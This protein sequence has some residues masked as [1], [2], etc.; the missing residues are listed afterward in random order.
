MVSNRRR[1]LR[2][3]IYSDNYLFLNGLSENEYNTIALYLF[4]LT[5]NISNE[6]GEDNGSYSILK[7]LSCYANKKER[8]ESLLQEF[9]DDAISNN[10]L[11]INTS[12]NI[13]QDNSLSL[14][15]EKSIPYDNYTKALQSESSGTYAKLIYLIFFCDE[16]DQPSHID[17]SLSENM[18]ELLRDTS[19]VD[20]LKSELELSDNEALILQI[21]YRFTIYSKIFDDFR[22]YH[23]ET[24]KAFSLV[25]ELPKY[26]IEHMLLK[27]QKLRE[28]DF[29]CSNGLLSDD[30]EE[31]IKNQNLDL[32]FSTFIKEFDLPKT[33]DLNSFNVNKEETELLQEMLAGNEPISILLYGKPGSGK[34][35]YAKSIAKESGKKVIIFKN[36]N[37]NSRLY[38]KINLLLSL[39]RPNTILIIDEADTILFTNSKTT[40]GYRGSSNYKGIV[41][42]I[43]ENSKNQVIWI[44]NYP[45]MMDESTRRRFTLSC[46]FE[47]M[48][49]EVL[50]NI[51]KTKLEQT[52]IPVG[53]QEKILS[54]LNTYRVTGSSVD[55]IIKAINTIHTN[56]EETL[57]NKINIILKENARLLNGSSSKRKDVSP[58]YDAS[59]LNTSI[60]SEKIVR[61]VNNAVRFAEKN[62]NTFDIK[63]GI[64]MLFYGLSG[65]GKTEFARYIS[66]NLG[67]EILIKRA[68]DILNKYVGG[69]EEKIADA[70]SEATANDQILLFDEADTFFTDR[71]MAEHSWERTKVN[72]FLMQMEDFQGILI[73]TTNLKNIMDSAMQRRFHI[74]V[75]FKASTREGIAKLLSG[76]F[77]SFSF[78]DEHISRLE[79]YQS[80]TP[81]DVSRLAET[82][83]FMDEE[84]ICSDF[85]VEEL[86]KIEEEKNETHRRVGFM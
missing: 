15:N 10:R 11:S 47:A 31:C 83:R 24:E 60:S 52:K 25:S 77:S 26:E 65:T 51:T 57:L 16:S 63:K 56:D 66:Q 13:E 35:E 6:F 76:Y 68:S 8:F 9:V 40:I 36:E 85:I 49:A 75:E 79:R 61:M 71:N 86:C 43:L 4:Q 72:E 73:C 69:T 44:V 37:E 50:K 58:S 55:N 30:V 3:Y 39:N 84:E 45:D 82:I 74:S 20:F 64:R 59:V 2:S 7:E 78:T 5:K 22:A 29:I 33:Y 62:Q 28:Y 17:F 67:K 1:G 80:V 14:D 27:N 38:G 21:S 32:Y 34:T 70:F 23:D 81:G 12:E 41:N 46:R 19:T 48:P 42:K 18:L 54:L 53:S